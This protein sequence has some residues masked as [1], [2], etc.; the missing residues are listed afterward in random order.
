MTGS[1]A[2]GPYGFW[3]GFVKWRLRRVWWALT[4]PAQADWVCHKWER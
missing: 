4:A 1:K 2:D 3:L